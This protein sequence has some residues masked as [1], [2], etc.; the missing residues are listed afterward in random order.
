MGQVVS[1]QGAILSET[2]HP[3]DP[4][5]RAPYL[6]GRVIVIDTMGALFFSLALLA[7]PLLTRDPPLLYHAFQSHHFE[8]NNRFTGFDQAI[9]EM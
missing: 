1:A 9:A 8:R 6:L 7:P 4:L 3:I 5:L 2:R